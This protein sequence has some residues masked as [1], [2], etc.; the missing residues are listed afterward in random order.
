MGK[1]RG[2]NRR[3][4]TEFGDSAL[5]NNATYI[6]YYER[7]KELAISMFE[8]ENL[9]DSCDERYLELAL[10]DT[11]KA[12]FF[13]DEELD[14]LLCLRVA[15]GGQWDIYNYPKARRA[16]ATNSYQKNLTEKD[17]VIIFN[18]LLRTNSV[19]QCRLFAERLTNIDRI[20]DVNVR[21]QKTPVLIQGSEQQRMTLVNLYKEFEGNAPV[22]F[23][24]KNLDVSGLSVLKTDAPYVSDKLYDLKILIWNEALTYFGIS[25][26]NFQKKERLISDEVSRQMG[27]TIASRYSRLEARRQAA[28]KINDMFGTNIN[29]VYREDYREMDNEILFTGSTEHGGITQLAK[30]QKSVG[31]SNE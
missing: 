5:K 6:F 30:N 11:G 13:K 3:P 23:G 1:R 7:L 26:V 27:A 18:N 19:M 16:Y 22:I 12:V 20:I 9:P 28:N 17:S 29:V 10:F 8:W 25:N 15:I 21:A 14:E 24:D 31:D 4:K 2:P